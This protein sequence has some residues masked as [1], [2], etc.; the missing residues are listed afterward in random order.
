M[1]PR[2]RKILKIDPHQL[3]WFH[4]ISCSYNCLRC[5]S[6]RINVWLKS[7]IPTNILFF[8]I[9]ENK[10]VWLSYFFLSKNFFN[11]GNWKD[12]CFL[13]KTST[14]SF[15]QLP[16]KVLATFKL[17]KLHV[18]IWILPTSFLTITQADV[19]HWI[20]NPVNKSGTG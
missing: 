5:S 12:I 11:L 10:S 3:K 20:H 15:W 16:V 6:Y 8:T 2:T 1:F 9:Y 4:S 19:P 7:I 17:P 18:C 14:S 13:I